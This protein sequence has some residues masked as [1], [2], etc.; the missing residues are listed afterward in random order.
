[1]KNRNKPKV[2]LL[3]GKVACGKTTYAREQQKKGGNVFLS[4]DE[5]QLGVFGQNPTREQLDSSYDG[6]ESYLKRMALSFLSNNVNVFLDWGFWSRNSRIETQK[7]FSDQG[8]EVSQIYFDVPF[9]VRL[10]RNQA[11][12]SGSDLHSFKIEEKDLALFDSFF[13]QPNADDEYTVVCA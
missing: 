8:Y 7:Y 12:N 9:S 10:Q 3:V 11:R 2:T 4:L 1:M 5:L 6:C 13:E